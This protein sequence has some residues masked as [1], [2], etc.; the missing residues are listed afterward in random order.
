M[1]ITDAQLHDLMD[2]LELKIQKS[3][4]SAS[5]TV[6]TSAIVKNLHVG[7]HDASKVFYWLVRNK[8]LKEEAGYGP[9]FRTVYVQ[10]ARWNAIYLAAVNSEATG[11]GVPSR[12]DRSVP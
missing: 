5:R 9:V 2:V 4:D 11:Y 1:D 12:I 7:W 6:L 3:P 8:V 10:G